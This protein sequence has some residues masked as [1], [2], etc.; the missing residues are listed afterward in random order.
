MHICFL[1]LHDV[2]AIWHGNVLG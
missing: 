1:R 2:I